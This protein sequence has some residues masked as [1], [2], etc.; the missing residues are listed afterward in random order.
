MPLVRHGSFDGEFILRRAGLIILAFFF[1]IIFESKALMNLLGALSLLL[2]LVYI[3][4]YDRK[5]VQ[6]DP[7]LLLF[8]V[9]YFIGFLFG[10]L[11]TS[12]IVGALAFL[13]RFKFMLLVLPLAAFVNER[14]D[15]NLLLATFFMSAIIAVSYGI[16]TEQPYGEF[17]GILKIGR[18]ADMMVVACLSL[19]VY[20]IHSR[21]RLNIKSILFKC[22]M[23]FVV[24][25]FSW[26]IMMS[27]MRGAWLG[28]SIGCIS[29]FCVLL[30]IHR[31]ALV[32]NLAMLAVIFTVFY[33]GNI[34]GVKSN[35]SRI[36]YQLASIVNTDNNYSNSARL[37]LW[38][39]GWDFSKEQ[40]IFGTGA[41]QSKAMFIAFFTAQPDEYQQKY[42]WAMR[43]PDESHN[44]YLQIHIET[45]FVFL[46]IYVLSI[47][48]IL[49][50]LL[51]N[52]RKIPP[53]DQK[54]LLATII[55]SVAFMSTQVFHSDLYHYGSTAFYL[56]LFSGCYV[57]NQ[58]SSSSWFQKGYKDDM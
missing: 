5:I 31:K 1:L 18:T 30:C 23:A 25:L 48:Y 14:K 26:A 4:L 51:K 17:Q 6:S 49:W 11:S 37:H 45:G 7:Y 22:L 54:Y 28:F 52:I 36:H 38:T 58:Y 53:D 43:Y 47:S 57:Q 3:S 41:K 55:A 56:I 39:T 35:I 20:L 2:S 44:S 21:F 13:G 12:G 32:L 27:E 8:I 10:F 42:Q 46:F 50:V 9:P 15:L 40:F 19:L 24:A 29:F 34:G 33:W 16:Y